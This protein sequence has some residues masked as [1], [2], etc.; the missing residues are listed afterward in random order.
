MHDQG[1][2]NTYFVSQFIRD[3]KPDI[4]YA[5]QGKV[6]TTMER[7]VLLVKIQQ[8]IQDKSEHKMQRN[9]GQL[10]LTGTVT[11]KV[12]G[13][14]APIVSQ[15]PRE[16]QMGDYYRANNLCFFCKENHM[17]LPMQLNPQKGPKHK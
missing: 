14:K 12:E 15:H 8:Q 4:R 3:L 7:A 2:G 13:S 10:R 1:M 6:P 5:V 17:M 11:N 16:K 9:F